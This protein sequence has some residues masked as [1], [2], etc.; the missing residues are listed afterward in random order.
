[1]CKISLGFNQQILESTPATHKAVDASCCTRPAQETPL[2]T[3]LCATPT[4]TCEN[5][6]LCQKWQHSARD[7]RQRAWESPVRPHSC[8]LLC[9]V[10]SVNKI[11]V[12]LHMTKLFISWEMRTMIAVLIYFPF[13][14]RS[15]IAVEY[16]IMLL[17]R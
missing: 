14:I 12:M 16:M 2:S 6:P 11:R 5:P 13:A 8:T 15:T 3:F 1:L 17:Y 9:P 10:F 7:D 4:A